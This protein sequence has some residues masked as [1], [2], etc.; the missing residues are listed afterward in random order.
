[1]LARFSDDLRVSAMRVDGQAGLHAVEYDSR[2]LRRSVVSYDV[3]RLFG[4]D[5]LL[6]ECC[7]AGSDLVEQYIDSLRMP[8]QVFRHPCVSR[9]HYGVAAKIHAI[10]ESRLDR[11]MVNYK[12]GDLHACLIIHRTFADLRA[13]YP[14]AFL[15]EL[16]IHVSSNVNIKRKCVQQLVHHA[17]CAGRTPH[18]KRS[19]TAF[20]PWRQQQI[21][22]GNDVI[23]MKVRE[24][25]FVEIARAD[26][27][28]DGSQ[29]RT[30]AAIEEK[31]L[32]GGF[33]QNADPV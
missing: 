5:A 1:M 9:H 30:A 20:R 2:F 22:N 4:R 31:L 6:N 15:R 7:H 32:S 33:H 21:R 17:A 25:N 24:K 26:A 12:G 19:L 27:R 23:G 28:F 29:G 16:L 3:G 13:D 8:D 10:A 18:L 11:T 14:D